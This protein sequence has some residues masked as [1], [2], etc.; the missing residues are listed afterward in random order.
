[1]I[2]AAQGAA[3]LQIATAA[4]ATL[5][6]GDMLGVDGL[7]LRC[8]A[9]CTADSNGLLTV[10]LT[11][12]LRRAVPGL[13]RASTATFI[14]D[15]GVLQT[16]GVNVPR[17]QDGAL[18]VEGAATNLFLFSEQFD[19]AAWIKTAINVNANSAVSPD[20]YSTA[21]SL[22]PTTENLSHFIRSAN[23][24]FV[25]GVSYSQ[26]FFAKSLGSAGYRL[27]LR[28]EASAFTNITFADFD[29]TSGLMTGVSDGATALILAIGGGWFICSIT[30]TA[31]ITSSSNILMLVISSTGSQSHIGD[32]FSGVY[33]WGAQLGTS[34]TSYIPTTTAAATRAADIVR[35]VTLD[36]PTAPFRLAS[37]PAVRY[38]GGYAEGVTLDFVER[39]I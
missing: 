29:L 18:F 25:S 17:F 36:R 26:V 13:A 16:A 12:R 20:G 32:G 10:P 37:T 8:A 6:A 21:D 39:V 30:A 22:I 35:P 23:S 24:S 5:L 27:R 15:L 11:N 14:D 19:N 4:G 7:L 2:A 9:D 3:T 31:T 28:F 38:V 1:V 33:L 34:L